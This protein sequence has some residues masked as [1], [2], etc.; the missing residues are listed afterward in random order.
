MEKMETGIRQRGNGDR[1]ETERERS[2]KER[3][4]RHERQPPLLDPLTALL[5]HP[6]TQSQSF[7]LCHTSRDAVKSDEKAG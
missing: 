5:P 1:N 3:E 6:R 7:R 2:D 4:R